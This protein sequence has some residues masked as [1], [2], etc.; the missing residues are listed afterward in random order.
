MSDSIPIIIIISFFVIIIGITCIPTRKKKTNTQK[1]ILNMSEEDLIDMVF[2]TIKRGDSSSGVMI[3]IAYKNFD[4]LLQVSKELKNHNNNKDTLNG[5]D[6]YIIMFQKTLSK[7]H[8]E[9]KITDEIG[10]RRISWFYLAALLLKATK[11]A[12]QNKEYEN[13]VAE[14]WIHI[15]ESCCFLQNILEKNILWTDKEKYT[16]LPIESEQDGILHCLNFV[17]PEWLKNNTIITDYA[18]SK[19]MVKRIVLGTGTILFS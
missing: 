16:F 11:I 9:L 1:S 6:D 14:M 10:E 5:V 2:N 3:L 4:L 15:A 13:A 8:H 12:E 18:E 19:N 7:N 17:V